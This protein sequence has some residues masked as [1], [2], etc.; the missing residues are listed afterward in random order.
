M[1]LRPLLLLL[2]AVRTLGAPADDMAAAAKTFLAALTP[3][4][5]TKAAFV[6][7]SP[8]RENWHFIPKARN[9]LPL[10]EM[11][12]AQRH[13]AYA[14]L[15]SGLSHSGYG[16]AVTIMSLEQIL[17][18]LE[19]PNRKFPRDPELYF[20]S[21]FGEPGRK[22]AWGWRVEGHHLSVNFTLLDGAV[23]AG[24]PSFMG[25]N[26]G[27]VRTGGRAG[28]RVLGTE[29]DLARTLVHSLNDLQRQQ[30]VVQPKAPDDIL[31]VAAAVA[32]IGAAKGLRFS[33]MNADQ[34]DLVRKII[35]AYVGRLRGELAAADLKAMEAAG[36]DPVVVAWAGGL[37]RGQGHYY[38]IHGPTFLLEYD[39]TQNDANH[40]HA[41]WREFKGD[42]GRDV[43]A[44]H[45]RTAHGK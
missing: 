42:F 23:V 31:T 30:A 38:R 17:Q 25:T 22:D 20:V 21:V 18:D 33:D 4:Q 32:D 34:K 11:S 19:G 9:G 39:N 36:L 16:K 44:D 5:K 7:E 37:E 14:L 15:S 12:A 1:H 41:V 8:E 27:E 43:L 29:E 40:V 45:L 26:P 13:L 35:N 3:D 6:F 10:K 24:T 28:L 2:L